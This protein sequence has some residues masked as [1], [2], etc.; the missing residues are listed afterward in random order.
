MACDYNELSIWRVKL[1]DQMPSICTE[2]PPCFEVSGA[3]L[4]SVLRHSMRV[5][6]Y[7][8]PETLRSKLSSK[9]G[10]QTQLL[11]GAGLSA[12]VHSP[13]G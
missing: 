6:P 8:G 9:V 13:C 1:R 2:P 3:S 11:L 10:Y 5:S 4:S 12:S 7:K